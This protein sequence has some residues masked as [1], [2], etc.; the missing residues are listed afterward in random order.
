MDPKVDPKSGSQE[1]SQS[2]WIPRVDPKMKLA[3]NAGFMKEFARPRTGRKDF[4]LWYLR[5]FGV[6]RLRR[7]NFTHLLSSLIWDSVVRN[8]MENVLQI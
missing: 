4:V 5:Q 6:K 1:I 3:G 7:E 8:V 2:K